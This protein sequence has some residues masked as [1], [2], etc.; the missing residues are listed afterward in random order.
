MNVRL[1]GFVTQSRRDFTAIFIFHDVRPNLGPTFVKVA[2]GR[3]RH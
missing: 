1:A 2:K 3:F